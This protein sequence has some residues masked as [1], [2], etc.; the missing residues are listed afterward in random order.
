ME[1]VLRNISNLEDYMTLFVFGY[2]RQMT[3]NEFTVDNIPKVLCL[4]C[5]S[6]FHNDSEHF[7]RCGDDITISNQGMTI[8]KTRNNENFLNTSYGN[9]WIESTSDK[10]VRWRFKQKGH[11][12]IFYICFVSTDNRL[13]NDCINKLDAPNYGIGSDG[14]MWTND[15]DGCVSSQCRPHT[16]KYETFT[17]FLHIPKGRVSI[18]NEYGGGY[19]IPLGMKK[20]KN[21]KYKLG[22]TLKCKN[23]SLSLTGFECLSVTN[24]HYVS[25]SWQAHIW[26]D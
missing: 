21:I 5:L 16:F 19:Y 4:I 10:M 7:V 25:G 8:T 13:N 2:I 17:I 1:R 26:D 6:F 23:E 18:H 15:D 11:L 24:D 14:L 9:I 22:I 20:G 12:P 3:S